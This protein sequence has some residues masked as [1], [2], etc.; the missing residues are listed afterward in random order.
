MTWAEQKRSIDKWR[1]DV[2]YSAQPVVIPTRDPS[3]RRGVPTPVEVTV[4]DE[5]P[6]KSSPRPVSVREY[7]SRIEEPRIIRRRT[8]VRRPSSDHGGYSRRRSEARSPS[9]TRTVVER[10]APSRR[11]SSHH[12]PRIVREVVREDP[13]PRRSSR[14]PSRTSPS[15][16]LNSILPSYRS[17]RSRALTHERGP[18]YERS[19]YERPRIREVSPRYNTARD[20]QPEHI[21]YKPRPKSVYSVQAPPVLDSRKSMRSGSVDINDRMRL[22]SVRDRF[23]D[24]VDKTRDWRVVTP[25]RY[26]EYDRRSVR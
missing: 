22:L 24:E 6:S 8:L 10:L 18:S 5:L 9:R 16:F 11:S 20:N 21:R 1:K 13:P 14:A 2:A 7:Q 15:S 23:R 3:F 19:S 4:D 17:T 26:R 12:R 25:E